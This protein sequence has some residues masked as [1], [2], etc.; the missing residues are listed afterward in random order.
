MGRI[1][2][3]VSSGRFGPPLT[4][5]GSKVLRIDER[6]SRS[7]NGSSRMFFQLALACESKRRAMG[8]MT[9]FAASASPARNRLLTGGGGERSGSCRPHWLRLMSGS[10]HRHQGSSHFISQRAHLITPLIQPRR[11]RTSTRTQA[12]SANCGSAREGS[13]PARRRVLWLSHQR[14]ASEQV[15]SAQT[16]VNVFFSAGSHFPR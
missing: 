10:M 11:T 15:R 9:P 2:L 14:E 3:E 12:P 13:E 7:N 1:R 6:R 8:V 16:H 5:V 4:P